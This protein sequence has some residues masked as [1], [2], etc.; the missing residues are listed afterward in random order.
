MKSIE[1]KP[2]PCVLITY[3]NRRCTKIAHSRT[4][5]GH[6]ILIQVGCSCNVLII[7]SWGVFGLIKMCC[8]MRNH[9]WLAQCCAFQTRKVLRQALDLS[10]CFTQLADCGNLFSSLSIRSVKQGTP[11]PLWTTFRVA[12]TAFCSRDNHAQVNET[13]EKC[14]GFSLIPLRLGIMRPSNGP[15]LGCQEGHSTF[16]DAGL[17]YF[18]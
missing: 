7:E 12:H 13:S 1:P 17:I 2:Y 16:P 14:Y 8:E 6:F 18:D 15:G 5:G 10:E 3:Q 4:K 11:G 9:L